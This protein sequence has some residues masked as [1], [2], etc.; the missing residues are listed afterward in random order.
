MA[1]LDDR[2]REFVA[3]MVTDLGKAILAVALA[4]YFFERFPLWLRGVLPS[5]GVVF[6]VVSVFIHP[7]QRG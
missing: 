3:R 5:L 6:L 4:S 1:I 2:R 7:K